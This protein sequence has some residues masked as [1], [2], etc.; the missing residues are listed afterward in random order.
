MATE[1]AT[2]LIPPKVMTFAYV[3]KDKCAVEKDKKKGKGKNKNKQPKCLC[4]T[5]KKEEKVLQLACIRGDFAHFNVSNLILL[6][7][8]KDA[9]YSMVKSGIF[10]FLKIWPNVTRN[11]FVKIIFNASH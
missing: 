11:I 6:L 1:K 3:T 8:P 5:T 10:V 4:R 9:R 7:I 2:F